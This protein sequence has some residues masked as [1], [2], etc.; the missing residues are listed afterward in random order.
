MTPKITE[1]CSLPSYRNASEPFALSRPPTLTCVVDTLLTALPSQATGFSLPCHNL[2]C[3]CL[4]PP[5][6]SHGTAG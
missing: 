2:A 3:P 5:R 1:N 4:S 6:D